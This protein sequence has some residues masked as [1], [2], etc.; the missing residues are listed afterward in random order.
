MAKRPEEI[1]EKRYKTLLSVILIGGL[2]LRI[3]TVLAIPT[4]PTEDF[5]SYFH[6]AISLADRG[7]YEA[8]PGK[9]D[10]SYPPGYPLL[11]SL[12]FKLPFKRLAVAK[13]LNILLSG[14]GLVLIIKITRNLFGRKASL[15]A[16]LIYALSP[17]S[18]LSCVLI[19]SENLFTPLV[20]LWVFLV[21]RNDTKSSF[22]N[23]MVNGL[24]LGFA[25]LTR[26]ISWL[27]SIPW[28]ISQIVLKQPARKLVFHLFIMV[29]AQMLVLTPWALRNGAV[30]GQATF[31][32]TTSG[33]NLFIGNNPNATGEWYYWVDDIKQIVPDFEQGSIAMQNNTAGKVA[34]QWIIQNPL[35]AV[36]LYFQKW[37]LIFKNDRFTLESAIF[38]KQLSP[39]Y[40]PEDV[41]QDD[42]A[43]VQYRQTL[44]LAF[45]GFYWSFLLLGFV[46]IVVSWV[47]NCKEP[48]FLSRWSLLLLSI[49]YF[50][51]TSAIFLASTRFHWTLADLLIPFAGGLLSITF[52]TIM[53]QFPKAS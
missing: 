15:F 53:S 13:T 49:L 48:H 37:G 51:T 41:L 7:V 12:F 3:V 33:I 34:R 21:I 1:Q 11:L 14:I 25:T 30:L 47:K 40:P 42:S 43:F 31:L 4:I 6:R 35:D 52:S 38:A 44:Y 18:I 45:D 27:L 20:L 46:G 19:A 36:R 2:L 24:V 29:A 39:P 8:I 22:W 26:S 23:P 28:V 5:W 10:A 32:T 17:R 16:G 50:P 9:P